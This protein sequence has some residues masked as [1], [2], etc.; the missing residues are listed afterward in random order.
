MNFDSTVI[1]RNYINKERE[2]SILARAH[3][4][5]KHQ[6]WEQLKHEYEKL[7]S[8]NPNNGHYHVSYACILSRFQ[9]YDSISDEKMRKLCQ[10][11]CAIA[12]QL[13]PTNG[14]F[15]LMSIQFFSYQEMN[16][17][18]EEYQIVFKQLLG[19]AEIGANGTKKLHIYHI[20]IAFEF[21][22]RYLFKIAE[23]NETIKYLEMAH[24]LRRK[25]FGK[26][27]PSKLYELAQAYLRTEQVTKAIHFASI[28][29]KINE[30]LFFKHENLKRIQGET[31]LL[32][33]NY[34]KAYT[35]L[36]YELKQIKRGNVIH[37][38]LIVYVDL[39]E[40]CIELN[41]FIEA[42][43]LNLE[44]HRLYKNPSI[45]RY[46]R[47]KAICWQREFLNAYCFIKEG[48]LQ[49][50]IQAV[51]M[52]EDTTKRVLDMNLKMGNRMPAA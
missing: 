50:A 29:E 42:N 17:I 10:K 6:Q 22:S 52:M 21:Y 19:L 43:K 48:G 35:L 18:H 11:H 23:Y 38:N 49:N 36:K 30:K 51:K 40:C 32:I 13:E 3:K 37:H 28:M 27:L 20:C 25:H 45:L 9:N 24:A 8:I 14:W 31:H 12:R 34:K 15:R 33:E 39:I 41:K 26:S 16:T 1:E 4:F 46:G 5:E 44:L 7:V 2:H 47:N